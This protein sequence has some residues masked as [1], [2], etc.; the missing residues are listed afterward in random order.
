VTI[1]TPNVDW[2][3]LS[4]ELC[5]LAAAAVCMLAAVLVPRAVRRPLSA[6]V[7]GLG[8]AGAFAAA[9]VL[10]VQSPT[11][12]PIVADSIVRDR[13]GCVVQLLVAGAGFVAVLVAYSQPMR[14]DQVGEY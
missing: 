12:Q 4:P 11:R 3:A 13:W 10:Y 5:L 8:F 7:C 9:V 14:H 2:F 6:V 1:Q